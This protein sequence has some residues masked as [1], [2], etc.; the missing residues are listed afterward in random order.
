MYNTND[1]SVYYELLLDWM[2]LKNDGINLESFFVKHDIH[3]IALYGMNRMADLFLD[4]LDTSNIKIKY[5]MGSNPDIAVLYP[6]LEFRFE[7][8]FLDVDAVVVF[9]IMD[10]INIKIELGKHFLCPIY[11]IEEIIRTV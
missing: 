3:E 9:P 6:N 11:S 7:Q 5:I 10:Y 4:E 2:N 1:I 8:D